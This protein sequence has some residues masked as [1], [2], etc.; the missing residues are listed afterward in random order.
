MNQ[1]KERRG[2]NCNHCGLY[3]FKNQ[4]FCFRAQIHQLED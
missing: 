1:K 3:N 2:H 4:K